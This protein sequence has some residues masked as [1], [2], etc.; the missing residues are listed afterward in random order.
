MILLILIYTANIKTLTSK[1][2]IYSDQKKSR[3]FCW[4]NFVN[5]KTSIVFTVFTIANGLQGVKAQRTTMKMNVNYVVD[6][7]AL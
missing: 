6:D 1:T 2:H 3:E 5:L 4:H 7:F